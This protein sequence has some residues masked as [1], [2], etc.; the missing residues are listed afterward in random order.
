[1][2]HSCAALLAASH[3][4]SVLVLLTSHSRSITGCTLEGHENKS[5]DD[6]TIAETYFTG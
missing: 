2:L 1:M 3:P 4:L 5:D 6:L